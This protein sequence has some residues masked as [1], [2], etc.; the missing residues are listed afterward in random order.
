[1]TGRAVAESHVCTH[2]QTSTDG[3]TDGDHLEVAGLHLLLERG[4]LEDD[5][6]GDI[7]TVGD[8]TPG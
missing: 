4:V 6:V 2:K 7:L 1:M 5:I 8:L 3:A